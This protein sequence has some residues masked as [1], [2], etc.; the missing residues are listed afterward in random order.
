M[1]VDK[2]ARVWPLEALELLDQLWLRNAYMGLIRGRLR[3]LLGFYP[4]EWEVREQANRHQAMP[5]GRKGPPLKPAPGW[6]GT[7]SMLG[8]KVR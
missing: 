2:Q 1:S 8:G 6:T 7:F 4:S 3:S 5:P